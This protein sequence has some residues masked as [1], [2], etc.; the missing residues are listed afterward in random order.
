VLLFIAVGCHAA[1]SQRY[2]FADGANYFLTLL[3]TRDVSSFYPA[4]QYAHWLTQ[5]PTVVLLRDLGSTDVKLAGLTYGATI[6]L[7]P[8]LGLIAAWWSTRGSSVD[9]MLFPLLSHA[10]LF[11]T[12]SFFATAESH[13]APP[14]FWCLLLTFVA[15]PRITPLRAALLVVLALAATRTYE[16]FL[17][18]SWPLLYAAARRAS[19]AWAADAVF[20]AGACAA[21][22]FLLLCAA[23]VS[24]KSTIHPVDVGQ[25]SEFMQGMMRHLSYPPVWFSLGALIVCVLCFCVRLPRASLTLLLLA[26]LSGGIAVCAV[27]VRSPESI[28]P[29]FQY[30]ARVQDLYVTLLLGGT[31][32]LRR[33]PEHLS[34]LPRQR[35]VVWG[36]VVVTATVSAT[37]QFVAT[38]QWN[39]YRAALLTDLTE[40]E[41]LIRF[42]DSCVSGTGD[43]GDRLSQ[44]NWNWAM[45]SLSVALGALN[46]DAVPAIVENRDVN[47]WEPFDPRVPEEI[48]RL[49]EYGVR[50][51]FRE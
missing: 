36:V 17:F 8:V 40:R 38:R 29:V 12:G 3:Q 5:F 47:E 42:E 28:K 21:S 10:I 45:P 18:L 9:Y 24:L 25:R 34:A 1:R 39:A 32:L 49:E 13:V 16:S 50:V 14:L 15:S 41:G 30:H 35:R 48:P 23:A 26:V 2:L 20:E 27:A 33:V 4:R 11:L 44:F 46:L 22:M 6:F 19:R 51:R 37:W 7:L 31:L 43:T